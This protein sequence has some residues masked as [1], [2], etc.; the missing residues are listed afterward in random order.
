[1]KRRNNLDYSELVTLALP[2]QIAAGIVIAYLAI[3]LIEWLSDND[4]DGP[5]GYA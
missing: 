3:N 2:L 1:M 5:D 4:D